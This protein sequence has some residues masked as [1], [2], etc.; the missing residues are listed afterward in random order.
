MDL[1]KLKQKVSRK[2]V[3]KMAFTDLTVCYLGAPVKEHYP[4][5][6][7]D[8][9]TKKD[10]EGRDLRA[11]QPDGYTFTFSE[12]G[13]SRKVSVVL[14]KK[15]SIEWLKIFSVSGKGYQMNSANLIFIDEDGRIKVEK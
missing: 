11:T 9:K 5:L 13:T 6:K 10:D 3:S 14:D 4:K 15:Y 1:A 2:S 7:E 8:G 12:L